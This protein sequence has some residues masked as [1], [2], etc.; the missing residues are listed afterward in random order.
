MLLGNAGV[1]CEGERGFLA[2]PK[3]PAAGIDGDNASRHKHNDVIARPARLAL[4]GKR[5]A[6]VDFQDWLPG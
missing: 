2:E 6:L 1:D 4:G 5:V 3:N